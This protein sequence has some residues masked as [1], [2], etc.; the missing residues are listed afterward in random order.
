MRHNY[1]HFVAYDPI[2]KEI[3]VYKRLG[4]DYHFKSH[5]LD[6]A[7]YEVLGKANRLTEV[8]LGFSASGDMY[9]LSPAEYGVYVKED[10]VTA[11]KIHKGAVL[12]AISRY[13]MAHHIPYDE[14]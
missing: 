4:E 10:S 2:K 7:F 3:S 11:A 1:R 5:R 14:Y 6:E 13:K 9:Q 8:V 12:A